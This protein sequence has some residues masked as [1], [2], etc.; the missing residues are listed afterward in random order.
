MCV[1]MYVLS[2][3]S[4]VIICP[5]Q[6]PRKT[7][8]L[9]LASEYLGEKGGLFYLVI[10]LG[11]TIVRLQVFLLQILQEFLLWLSGLRN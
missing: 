1:Y 3:F 10:W 11:G 6:R 4:K 5:K 9:L 2:R 8:F 7:G